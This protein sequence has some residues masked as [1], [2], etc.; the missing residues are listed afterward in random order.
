MAYQVK[1]VEVWSGTMPDQTGALDRILGALAEAGADLE[2]VVARRQPDQPGTGHVYLT[3]VTGKKVAAAAKAAGLTRSAN[4][5]TLRVEG[6]NKPGSGHQAMQ[7]IADAGIN[8]RGISA[9][10]MGNKSIAY[11]GLDS[12]DDAA[13]ATKALKRAK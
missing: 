2:C 3:P 9:F 5:A 10:A 6:P 1:K 8:V 4:I 7:A 12:A 13:R 11:I